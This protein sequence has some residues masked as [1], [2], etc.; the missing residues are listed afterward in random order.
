MIDSKEI[1]SDLQFIGHRVSNFNLETKMVDIKGQRIVVS[2]EFDYNVIEFDERDEK[3]FGIIEFII[4]GK[5][6]SG[7]AI[8][9]KIDLTMEGAFIGNKNAFSSDHFK[10]ILE[11]NGLVTLSQISRSF[12]LSVTSQSGISPPV[13]IPMINVNTL[14]TKKKEENQKNNKG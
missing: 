13:R 2:Y 12:L 5:A 8:L 3:H 1:A 4:R 6:K 11:V 9:F 10:E 14:R 7:K